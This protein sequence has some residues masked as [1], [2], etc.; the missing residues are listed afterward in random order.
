MLDA[1]KSWIHGADIGAGEAVPRAAGFEGD[2]ERRQ[3]ERFWFAGADVFLFLPNDLSFRL[4]LKDVSCDGL[5]GLTDAPLSIGETVLVQFEETFMPAAYVTWTRNAWV[6]LSVV[7]PLPEA[8]LRRLCERHKAG[9]AWSPAMRTNS[10]LAHWWTDVDEV[11]A[12][13]KA[14]ITKKARSAA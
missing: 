13:R 11:R 1:L 14:K 7:N 8:R 3:G 4:R 9:A 6:G 2:D 10:D 5:S 12:G